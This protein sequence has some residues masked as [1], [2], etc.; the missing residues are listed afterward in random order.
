MKKV[1]IQRDAYFDSV[2]LM[3]INRDVRQVAGVA[4]A[5]VAM[6]TEMNVGLLLDLGYPQADLRE[7]TPNDLI[8]AVEAEDPET[9]EKALEAARRLLVARK[10]ASEGGT[11]RPV[12]L[13]TAFK[14]LPDSNLVIVSVPGAYAAREARK[15]LM[16]GRHVMLFSDNVAI[17]Q[18]I[19]LKNLARE[20][21]LLMMGPDCGTAI[22]NGK[23]LCFANSVSRG[24]IGLVSASGTGLQEVSCCIDRL[25]GGITQAI[26][27]GGR[28]LQIDRVG[29]T[30]MLMGIE[31]LRDDPLTGVIVVIS[32]PPAP[33]IAEKVLEALEQ[34]G[35]PCVV[36]FIGLENPERL[37][38]PKRSGQGKSRLHFPLSLEDAAVRAVALATGREPDA[39][40]FL[41]DEEEMRKRVERE[42]EGMASGQRYLRG[43]FT[44]G[45]LA[46]EALI[47]FDR[48]IG[49]VYSNNQ[50]K[51]ELKLSDPH[52]SRGHTVVDL[53]DDV[54]TVGRPHP[55]IDPSVRVERIEREMK[56]PEVAVLHLDLVLGY[57]AHSDP[58]GALLE[59]LEKAKGCVGERG[60]YLAV[61]ASVTGTAGDYQNMEEQREKLASAGCVVMPSNYQASRLALEIVKK[62]I[63]Q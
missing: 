60:G 39:R 20:R 5:V 62:R 41:V 36:H 50:L 19:E 37:R 49:S 11:Y 34:T 56:D 25:G 13:E 33:A 52:T 43:L 2:F 24:N 40:S 12:S 48:E 17:E 8:L 57:G 58:A 26:G 16:H 4:D 23:P 31:A 21:G 59:A 14:M 55:M 15:A 3:L 54:F 44:G 29:G 32:K 18:E 47:L 7:A 51:P 27:T 63:D 61:V 35:K 38:R 6:G 30:M 10:E 46:D 22:I 1:V 28:D 9:I 53:G 42:T 45:T